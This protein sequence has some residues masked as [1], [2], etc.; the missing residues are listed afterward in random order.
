VTDSESAHISLPPDSQYLVRI[1]TDDSPG[2]YPIVVNTHSNNLFFWA[3][4]Y[5][6]SVSTMIIMIPAIIGFMVIII[7]FI[8]V[9]YHFPRSKLSRKLNEI[10]A[11]EEGRLTTQRKPT[12]KSD[13]KQRY[14]HIYQ[15]HRNMIS[16]MIA[17][18]NL[19][20]VK[21]NSQRTEANSRDVNINCKTELQDV[22]L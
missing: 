20:T 18:A 10:N 7:Y 22:K 14:S 8:L 4:Y 11:L 1:T 5:K 17:N 12:K 15:V 2:S 3:H 6:K 13:E 9:C 19:Q 16:E 21:G